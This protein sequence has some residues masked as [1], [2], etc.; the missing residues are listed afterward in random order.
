MKY[1]IIPT[2]IED[3][4]IGDTIECRDGKIRTVGKGNLHYDLN[5]MGTLLF[6][7]CYNCG[8]IPVKKLD[9][10]TFR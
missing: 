7:D 1:R 2:H 3:I 9:I 6:G 5:G 10:Y 8:Y 4:K